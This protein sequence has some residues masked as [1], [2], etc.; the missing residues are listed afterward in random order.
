MHAGGRPSGTPQRRDGSG[1]GAIG[2]HLEGSSTRS[3]HAVLPGGPGD[4]FPPRRSA[5]AIALA[6]RPRGFRRGR[7][8]F[9]GRRRRAITAD[10]MV[11][12][13]GRRAPSAGER[14]AAP[15]DGNPGPWPEKKHMNTFA[16]PASEIRTAPT[17]RTTKAA[18]AAPKLRSRGPRGAGVEAK[19]R[20]RRRLSASV[21]APEGT[22]GAPEAKGECRDGACV[23]I[24]EK[25]HV[26]DSANRPWLLP[27]IANKA[28]G[29]ERDILLT[30]IR[31]ASAHQPKH[32]PS[33]AEMVDHL[34][35][36][37]KQKRGN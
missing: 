7:P 23:L 21:R 3:R 22:R 29:A 5:T 36:F 17:A 24:S 15:R 1:R 34:D 18:A 16:A 20:R 28:T 9:P 27:F 33:F 8:G 35:R 30:L 25:T 11:D 32:R 31:H 10:A 12:L 26:F 37:E 4:F 19:T 13:L 2:A 6:R 14:A